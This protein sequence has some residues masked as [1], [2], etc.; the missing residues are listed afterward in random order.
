MVTMDDEDSELDREEYRRCLDETAAAV[1]GG[2]A[3]PP[4]LVAE[5]PCIILV[6]YAA[7]RTNKRWSDPTHT[8][9]VRR[10][11]RL[12]PTLHAPAPISGQRFD[13]AADPMRKT[14]FS[15]ANTPKCRNSVTR[16]REDAVCSLPNPAAPQAV[17]RD[18]S[19]PKLG[20]L[21]DSATEGI[22][23]HLPQTSTGRYRK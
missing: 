17:K 4:L 10:T 15:P 3:C 23:R 8:R 18:L 1:A 21:C 14:L 13:S 5:T 22:S 7:R 19:P 6:Q 12:I 20:V 2:A 9:L 16:R 11:A